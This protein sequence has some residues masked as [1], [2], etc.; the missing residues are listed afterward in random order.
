MDAWI[1][2]ARGPLFRISLT[3]CMLGLG[4][5]FAVTVGQIIGAWRRAGDRRV[6]VA[7]VAAA[8]LKWLVPV[9]LLR[10]RPL[11]SVASFAFHLGILIVPLFLAGHVVLLSGV[12]PGF[13]PT[14][15]ASI[16]DGLTIAAV[17][18]LAV[19]LGARVT[20]AASRSLTRLHDALILLLL[21][22]MVV[23]GFVAA[24]PTVSPF[25]AR[26]ILLLHV[27]LGNLV[28]VVIPLSKIS[29][30]V[31]YPL[32]QLVFQLGW[33]FPAESGRH[34]AIALAKENEPV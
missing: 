9:R 13:W 20:V 22:A 33:H 3:I 4:Y 8:T 27:L 31:L 1:E 2:V 26:T 29:H 28:L 5:R 15:P 25:P 17:T 24:H 12:L 32:T 7:D 10:I 6:P 14:L 19:L 21:L 18:A 23:F 11:T 16:A 34:V 30:C